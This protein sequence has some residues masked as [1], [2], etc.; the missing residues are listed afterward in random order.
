MM[1]RTASLPGHWSEPVPSGHA[2]FERHHDALD[3]EHGNAA[4]D[5][6]DDAGGNVRAAHRRNPQIDYARL[7]CNAE[8][9][10]VLIKVAA[11]LGLYRM[12][13]CFVVL[14]VNVSAACVHV[15]AE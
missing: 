15:A 11:T 5:E 12:Q 2:I 4:Q 14:E 13:L 7:R 3:A 8:E 6:G 10:H 9:Q 1:S